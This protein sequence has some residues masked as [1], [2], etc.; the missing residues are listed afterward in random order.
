MIKLEEATFTEDKTAK[1]QEK[2]SNS[3]KKIFK[4]PLRPSSF[5][6]LGEECSVVL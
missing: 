5:N 6:T 2:C 1:Y 4:P 3:T